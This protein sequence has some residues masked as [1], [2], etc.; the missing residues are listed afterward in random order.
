LFFRNQ[1]K[2]PQAHIAE[3][4]KGGKKQTGVKGEEERDA[5]RKQNQLRDLFFKERAIVSRIN[6]DRAKVLYFDVLATAH[7]GEGEPFS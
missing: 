3:R 2:G 4:K 6:K 1:N 7:W 5:R